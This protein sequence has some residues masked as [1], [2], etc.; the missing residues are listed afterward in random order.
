MAE[1]TLAAKQQQEQSGARRRKTGRAR[2]KRARLCVR[3]GVL[4]CVRTCAGVPFRFTLRGRRLPWRSRH[5]LPHSR[6]CIVRAYAACFVVPREMLPVRMRV[7]CSEGEKKVM[8][9]RASHSGRCRKSKIT[10][11]DVPAASLLTAVPSL[12]RSGPVRGERTA[13]HDGTLLSAFQPK[14]SGG[15]GAR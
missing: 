11:H 5:A 9:W 7:L 13:A 4:A 3:A 15:V 14:S 10:C 8:L 12:S 6:Q 2:G 1:K